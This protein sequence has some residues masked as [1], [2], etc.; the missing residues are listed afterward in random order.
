MSETTEKMYWEG[1]V[2]RLQTF[3]IPFE[4]MVKKV[5]VPFVTVFYQITNF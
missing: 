3:E 1:E 4:V 2:Y 5:S